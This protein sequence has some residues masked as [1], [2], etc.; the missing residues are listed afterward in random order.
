M[1]ILVNNAGHSSKVRSIRYVQPEDWQSVFNVN[2]EGVYRLT[3]SVLGNMIERG[4]GT[5][6]TVSSMAAISPGL[7]GRRAV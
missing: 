7:M 6:I 1:N 5:V 4:E 2:V 3:Q